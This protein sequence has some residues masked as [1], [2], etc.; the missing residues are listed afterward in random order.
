MYAAK[1]S[2]I[3]SGVIGASP[4]MAFRSSRLPTKNRKKCVSL[5]SP[6]AGLLEVK[7]ANSVG[8]REM[9]ARYK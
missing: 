9:S 8:S 2:K 3:S 4:H 7:I 5:S 6:K 1:V